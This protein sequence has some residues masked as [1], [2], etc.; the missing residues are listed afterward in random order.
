MNKK[1]LLKTTLLWVLVILAI[2]AIVFYGE[3][4]QKETAAKELSS[5]I[6]KGYADEYLVRNYYWKGGAGVLFD[7][8]T[9]AQNCKLQGQ[10]LV[11][12]NKSGIVS[13]NNRKY[14]L[15]LKR[16]APCYDKEIQ[17]ILNAK[18]RPFTPQQITLFGNF[19][20]T[21]I[22]NT[23][24]FSKAIGDAKADKKIYP[25]EF[26]NL[27][28]LYAT[29][30]NKIESQSQQNQYDSFF[31]GKPENDKQEE[32]KTQADNSKQASPNK[33]KSTNSK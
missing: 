33:E 18:Q 9:I 26:L 25:I 32:N 13:Y 29:I 4:Q 8:Y 17:S 20:N 22:V 27:T 14:E 28:K 23:V 2:G 1:A 7:T 6:A 24:A 15:N 30:Y 10:D 21:Q 19:N 16:I 31:Q 5:T 12:N 11:K 3:N